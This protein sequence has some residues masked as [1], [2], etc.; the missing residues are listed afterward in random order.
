MDE[1][2]ERFTNLIEDQFKNYKSVRPKYKIETIEFAY[3]IYSKS[4]TAYK[5]VKNKKTLKLP[6]ED[7]LRKL[8]RCFN[9][10]PD[11]KEENLEYL[12]IWCSK[13]KP[14]EK[15]VNLSGDEVYLAKQLGMKNGKISGFSSNKSKDLAQTCFC[16]FINSVLGSFGE[17]FSLTPVTCLKG[18]EIEGMVDEAIMQ[19][20]E[21][22]FI[23]VSISMDNHR[24][25]QR[26]FSIKTKNSDNNYSY[27]N[28]SIP[29]AKIFLFYDSIHIYKNLRNN[30]IAG[31]FS[32]CPQ[33][34]TLNFP[35]FP[36]SGG[37]QLDAEE[38]DFN[39]LREIFFNDLRAFEDS[40][41]VIHN[42]F[43]LTAKALWI[44]SFD[45]QREGLVHQ[46]FNERV[47][48][49]LRRLGKNGT[50]SFIEIVTMWEHLMNSK[51]LTT[52]VHARIPQKEPYRSE[53]D[54]KL[55]DLEDFIEW[56][57]IWNSPG[58]K[59]GKQIKQLSL[60]T[61]KAMR[62]TTEAMIHFVE[63]IFLTFKPK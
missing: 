37:H 39:D 31:E 4:P 7:Y 41:K 57:D 42:A 50:A 63:Y 51:N 32:K 58:F 2:E 45:R 29:G 19:L 11:I 43:G 22:G 33:A 13:L 56:L 38:A 25:N 16:L 62:Q 18:E 47:S 23:V 15:I 12:K 1:V 44:S 28:P 60:D 10:R 5:Q 35:V 54:P 36:G 52:G 17:I 14:E 59:K 34:P 3:L 53:N 6:H 24:I 21:I 40:Q 27:D 20:Q 8:Q 46:V 30:W 48:A 49:E 9:L 55:G 61:W 26:F